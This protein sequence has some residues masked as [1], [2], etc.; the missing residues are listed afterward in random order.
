MPSAVA[1]IDVAKTGT[2]CAGSFDT[3]LGTALATLNTHHVVQFT[4]N[5]GDL[6]GWVFEVIDTNGV[7]GYQ[8]G[9]GYVI[10]LTHTT[11]GAGF[12]GANGSIT[13]TGVFV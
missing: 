11:P 6:A 7:A 4:A 13:D 8:A 1:A 9:Q 10:E 12:G 3:D 5:A 2:L